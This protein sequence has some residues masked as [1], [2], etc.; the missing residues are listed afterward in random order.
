MLG[1]LAWSLPVTSPLA[2]DKSSDDNPSPE[3][4]PNPSA[5]EVIEDSPFEEL[6]V[7]CVE[8]LKGEACFEA[9]LGWHEGLRGTR[10]N[11]SQAY[12]LYK[13]GCGFGY[14]PACTAA[15][16]MILRAQAGFLILRPNGTLSLDFGEAARLTGLA[17]TMGTLTACGRYGDLMID[18]DAQLPNEGT[19]HHDIRRDPLAARQAY[20]DGCP[21][22][23]DRD[24]GAVERDPRSCKRL[25][26]FYEEG[27]AGLPKSPKNAATYYQ[28]GCDTGDAPDLCVKADLLE[29]DE[30]ERDES[31]GKTKKAHRS[32]IQ[33]QRP[34]P[35]VSRFRDTPDAVTYASGQEAHHRRFDVTLGLG[36]RWTYDEEAVTGM[37]LRIGAVIWFNMLGIAIDSGFTTDK[38]MRIYDRTYLRFQQGLGAQLAIPLPDNLPQPIDFRLVLGVGGT[39]GTL[40]RGQAGDFLLSYGLRER[41]QL[42]LGTSR[43]GGA[44]QWGAIRF[45]Q[46]QTWYADTGSRQ[47]HSSQVVLIAGFSFGGLDA[48]WTPKKN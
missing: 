34:R 21:L 37:K 23:S 39:L 28:L 26:Q 7:A 10:P 45:E 9:A 40:K 16:T 29:A 46:Q 1:F 20:M 14:A 32:S 4:N 22:P 31:P 17:C 36:A 5:G 27:I 3:F 42:E 44:R 24:L 41:V 15:A 47:E 11:P 12:H 33:P 6:E 43:R 38:F 8:G 2:Q 19:T 25:G 13:A 48:D 35:D 18:P 30:M